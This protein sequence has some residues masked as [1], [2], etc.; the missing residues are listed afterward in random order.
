MLSGWP[1]NSDELDQLGIGMWGVIRLCDKT[2]GGRGMA[3][4]ADADE[5]RP[6][7][8]GMALRQLRYRPGAETPAAWR[9]HHS[10]DDEIVFTERNLFRP[11]ALHI[12]A[13]ARIDGLHNNLVVEP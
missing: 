1:S 6:R 5:P 2:V 8:C 3:T 7:E 10:P 12:D 11:F 9:P 13:H 4:T